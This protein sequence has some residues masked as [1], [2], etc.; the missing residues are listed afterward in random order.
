MLTLLLST[1]FY[2]LWALS[3]EGRALVAVGEHRSS[4]QDHGYEFGGYL[5]SGILVVDHKQWRRSDLMNVN[6]GLQLRV[7]GVCDT[8]TKL[9]LFMALKLIGYL[10]LT[11]GMPAGIYSDCTEIMMQLTTSKMLLKRSNI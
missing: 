4:C 8:G 10:Y 9:F 11:A 3:L 7:P 1:V 5:N 6:V 2:P